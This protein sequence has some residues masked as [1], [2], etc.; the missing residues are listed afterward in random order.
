MEVKPKKYSTTKLQKSFAIVIVAS[1][2]IIFF[3][4]FD[5][6]QAKARDGKRKSDSQDISR[7]LDLYFYR[8]EKYPEVVDEDFADWDT[9]FEPKGEPLIFIPQLVEENILN[10][11][12]RD[13]INNSTYF[14]R[15][16]K[17]FAGEYGCSRNYIIFQV[18]NFETLQKD[19]GSGRCPDYDFAEEVPNGYTIQ[20]FE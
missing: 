20:K 16:R 19:P 9:T 3:S 2:A 18:Y 8:Y 4:S 1:V 6:I 12:P 17:F 10:S 13:P 5:D 7:A 11:V 15:Y 14:Y